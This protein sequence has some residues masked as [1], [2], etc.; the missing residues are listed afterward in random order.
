MIPWV[1]N[2]IDTNIP[3]IE[4]LFI[5]YYFKSKFINHDGNRYRARAKDIWINLT[6]L[7]FCPNSYLDLFLNW[8][9]VFQIPCY[10]IDT[11]SKTFFSIPHF[12]SGIHH[13]TLLKWGIHFRHWFLMP[14]LPSKRGRNWES[15]P[16]VNSWLYK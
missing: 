4:I 1:G 13:F 16:E 6:F 12:N 3:N 9:M 11:L 15:M 14:E 10:T 2:H 5:V 8:T 7:P